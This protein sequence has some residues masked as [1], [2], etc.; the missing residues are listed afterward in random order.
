MTPERLIELADQCVR[1]GLCLPHCPTYGKLRQEAESPRGRIALI[2]GWAGG[3]LGL[4]PGLAA[5]LDRCLGCRNCERACPSLVAYG[6]LADGAK[7]ARLERSPLRVR[8]ARGLRL[9][10]LAD[11]R[12]MDWARRLSRLYQRTGAARLVEALG[13]ARW[14]RIRPWHRI[15]RVIPTIGRPLPATGQGPADLELFV[16]CAGALA[17]GNGVESAIA[18]LRRLGLRTRIAPP[19]RCCGASAR[20]NGLPERA[21]RLRTEGLGRD[22]ALPLVALASACVA[23]LREADPVRPVIEICDHLER[24]LQPGRLR[25]APLQATCLVHEPCSHRNLLGGNA[26]VLRLLGRIPGLDLHPLPTGNG[27]CGAAGTYLLDQPEMAERLLGDLLSVVAQSAPTYLVTTNPGC[28]LHL[29]AGLREAG[30]P[31]RICHPVELLR[32]SADR[33]DHG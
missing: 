19:P 3:R 23:E 10:L 4:T 21:D 25:L 2:Q 31:T 24:S 14:R 5:H 17:Q 26:A 12:A 6:S 11:S 15:A 13:L 30:I 33:A 18:L 22:N 1:C 28:A 16:G 20:H 29:A 8:I 27:C 7:A 9:R 32:E